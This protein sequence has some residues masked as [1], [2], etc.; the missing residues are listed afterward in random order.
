MYSIDFEYDGQYLSDY[1]FI[2]CSFDYSG[3]S[4]TED[5]GS[6]LTFN[7][8]SRNSGKHYG[9]TATS[10]DSCIT[11]EFDICKN[12]DIYDDLEI[13]NGEFLDLMR[14]LNRRKFLKFHPIN[15]KET[16]SDTCYFDA[17]F[18]VEKIKVAEKLCGLHLIMET[19]KPFGYGETITNKWTITDTT[20]SYIVYDLSDEIGELYPD[21]KIV[22]GE[23]GDLSIH[24]DLTGSTTFIR[25]CTEGEEITIHGS[26]QI[27]ESN[28]NGHDIA[29]DF[30]Y[31]FLKIGNTY[32]NRTN[33]IT[34]TKQCTLEI[35]YAPI[36]KN[37]PW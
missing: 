5:A 27:I 4:V 3:G 6:T 15:D 7:T 10:Y 34:V 8:V 12:P 14:W 29:N 32:D 26:S 23:D 20:K 18:N 13:T 37:A 1:G 22:A 21:V 2:V 17:S 36:V 35:S 31:I 24:N 9:L 33:K 25:N 30:N 16:E 11:A 19:N 28:L